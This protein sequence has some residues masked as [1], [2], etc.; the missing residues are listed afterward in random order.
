MVCSVGTKNANGLRSGIHTLQAYL[1]QRVH[2][3]QL[4]EGGGAAQLAQH[5]GLQV[6][7]DQLVALEVTTLHPHLRQQ[8]ITSGVG[9]QED[10]VVRAGGLLQLEIIDQLVS[11][12]I[13]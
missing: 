12:F 7:G 4:P 9:G 3:R 5:V 13:D 6:M 10:R 8:P 1:V 2:F 11:R